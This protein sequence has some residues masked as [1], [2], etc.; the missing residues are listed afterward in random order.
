MGIGGI[1]MWQL[2]IILL[3]V[4]LIFGTKRLKGMGGDLGSAIKSFKK[5]VTEEEDK[6]SKNGENQASKISAEESD[7]SAAENTEKKE[8]SKQ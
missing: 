2:L 7:T 8:H 1:S 6:D 3:I 5:A 4:I